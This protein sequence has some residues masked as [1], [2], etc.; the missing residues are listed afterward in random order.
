MSTPLQA[1]RL[2][3]QQRQPHSLPWKANS[4][5]C[6]LARVLRL[7][8]RPERWAAHGAPAPSASTGLQ[9]PTRYSHSADAAATASTRPRTTPGLGWHRAAGLQRTEHQLDGLGPSHGGRGLRLTPSQQQVRGW[10][11]V[12]ERQM[13]HHGCAL[14]PSSWV[15]K[16]L[17]SL[18]ALRIWSSPVTSHARICGASPLV[19]QKKGKKKKQVPCLG[20]RDVGCAAWE[21]TSDLSARRAAAA[22]QGFRRRLC[23]HAR[24]STRGPR[25]VDVCAMAM[26]QQNTPPDKDEASCSGRGALAASAKRARSCWVQCDRCSKW[27]RLAASATAGLAD[28]LAWYGPASPSQRRPGRAAGTGPWRACARAALHPCAPPSRAG[29]AS[30]TRP[31]STPAATRRRS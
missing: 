22:T 18:G 30:R 11:T 14:R 27:R 23:R 28:G 8:R 2:Q 20:S 12:Q 7:L 24:G 16:E 1:R 15:P 9:L 5:S 19:R 17:C 13:A 26:R 25:Q 4:L 6:A 31:G 29:T 3:S 10:R 21:N